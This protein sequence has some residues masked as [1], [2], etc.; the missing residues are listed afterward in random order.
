MANAKLAQSEMRH[1]ALRMIELASFEDISDTSQ[2][3]D[4]RLAPLGVNL[5]AETINV[6]IDHIR[7]GLNPHPPNLGQ[8]H[9]ASHNSAS[10][11]AKVL[12][13]DE[14]LGAK[15]KNFAASGNP[16]LEEIKLQIANSQVST[17]L[18]LL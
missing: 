7:V 2:R 17:V 14:L 13:Q 6:N 11:A 8:E 10:V 4:Q 9:R 12:Q 15:V 16:S 5:A 18:G 1:A 3:L